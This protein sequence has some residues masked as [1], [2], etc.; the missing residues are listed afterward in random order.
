MTINEAL[1]KLQNLPQRIADE[2]VDLM[3]QEVPY[4]KGD[5][6]K[7][8]HA[9]VS[10]SSVFIGTDIHYAKY[11]QFGRGP[12]YPVQK[13]VLHW[14]G[15]YGDVFA[16]RAGPAKANDFVGRTARRLRAYISGG[17]L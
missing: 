1:L 16:M 9:E 2:G 3:K 4:D 13:K 14:E 11:V 12:V 6:E 7:S 10:T 15:K 5:L 17:L 8:I